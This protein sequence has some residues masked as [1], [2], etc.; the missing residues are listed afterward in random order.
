MDELERE[1]DD[2]VDFIKMIDPPNKQE[3]L[4]EAFNK[5]CESYNHEIPVYD[6][7]L[8]QENALVSKKRER[9]KLL[10]ISIAVVI[11]SFFIL[12]FGSIIQNFISF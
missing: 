3:L 11:Y 6:V 8:L 7:A 12:Y 5:Y 9:L 1:F 4:Q 10:L 2:R